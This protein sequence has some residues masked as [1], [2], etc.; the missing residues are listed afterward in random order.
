MDRGVGRGQFL[1]IILREVDEFNRGISDRFGTG[2][3]RRNHHVQAVVGLIYGWFSY[4]DEAV[5]A[6]AEYP[7]QE[8]YQEKQ[9]QITSPIKPAPHAPF[10]ARDLVK[11]VLEKA[12]GTDKGADQST[13][14]DAYGEQRPQHHG[15]NDVNRRTIGQHP[16]RTGV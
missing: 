7:G 15:R 8:E 2:I 16:D 11:K 10:R 5:R 9:G 4:G 3:G 6:D 14:D 1:A 13:G 12:K